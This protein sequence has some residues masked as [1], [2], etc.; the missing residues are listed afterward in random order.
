MA[1]I[2]GS[3]RCDERGKLSGGQPGDQTGK[4][5]MEQEFY[6]HK[7]GWYILR[8]KSETKARI[9]AQAMQQAC[10]NSNIGYNQNNRGGVIAQLN[11]YKTLGAIAIATECDCST[12]VRACCMQ[13]GINVSNF[14]TYNEVPALVSTGEFDNLGKLVSVSQV[15][16][17]DVLCTCSKG[18]T[19]VV[20]QAPART[21]ACV[22]NPTTYKVGSTYTVCASALSVRTGPGTNYRR[23]SHA[24]LSA[25]AKKHDPNHNGTIVNGTRISC[26]EL[27]TVGSDIWFRSPSGWMAAHYR[28]DVYIK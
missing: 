4:E 17:G 8:P 20:T 28:G 13:A 23:K 24:E 2:I 7:K 18:H 16:L 3:A 15:R 9:I 14:T 21:R 1:V 10:N 11:R 22:S 5:V 6:I 12:L 27:R 25:D 19:V 26:E